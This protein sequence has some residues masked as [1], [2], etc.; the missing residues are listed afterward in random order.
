[1]LGSPP[2]LATLRQLRDEP[3]WVSDGD[4]HAWLR[5]V[6]LGSESAAAAMPSKP[7][8]RADD[9]RVL[10]DFDTLADSVKS[11]ELSDSTSWVNNSDRTS[12]A[13][14][15]NSSEFGQPTNAA[16]AHSENLLLGSLSDVSV[17]RSAKIKALRIIQAATNEKG[18]VT[19]TSSSRANSLKSV[20]SSVGARS[21]S[22]KDYQM[23]REFHGF[24]HHRSGP[25]SDLTRR[26]TSSKSKSVSIHCISDLKRV[27]RGA[28]PV[29]YPERSDYPQMMHDLISELEKTRRNANVIP[30]EFKN[31]PEVRAHLNLA[32]NDDTID[33][34]CFTKQP[35]HLGNFE[36][37]FEFT[38]MIQI[39]AA[40]R[41]MS[42]RA[43]LENCWNH[44]VHF[45]LFDQAQTSFAD[46]VVEGVTQLKPQGQYLPTEETRPK[47]VDFAVR[48][49]PNDTDR[50]L[51]IA[52]LDDQHPS[53]NHAISDDVD[54]RECPMIIPVET[55]RLNGGQVRALAQLTLW[56]MTLFRRLRQ[57]FDEDY[58]FPLPIPMIMVIGDRWSL[59]FAIDG[60]KN[61]K[62]LRFG[63]LG[64]TSDL[65]SLYRLL[66]SL[67]TLLRFV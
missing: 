5:G 49:N 55:K 9:A 2:R 47:L 21:T 39:L 38:N 28:R 31:S 33:F 25:P 36:L 20:S 50:N 35:S 19:V 44:S 43:P 15:Y 10:S 52:L 48:W 56:A 16:A 14:S 1:M 64:V 26:S 29:D 22:T 37:R 6:E 40:S 34:D 4:F 62:I 7:Q 30:Q 27:P 61:T 17:K 8:E 46:L 67:K 41:S 60:M 59:Y 66:H 42:R 18:A 32:D 58:I 57:F 63:E 53:I 45:K 65:Q 23:G 13:V 54:Y 11:L 51:I 3:C 12:E 24:L